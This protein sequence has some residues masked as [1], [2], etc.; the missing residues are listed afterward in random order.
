MLP[1][2]MLPH[3]DGGI[4]RPAA[5]EA[6]SSSS[7]SSS[8]SPGGGY[9]PP[10]PDPDP[11]DVANAAHLDDLES[12]DAVNDIASFQDI[13]LPPPVRGPT[14][15]SSAGINGGGGGGGGGGGDDDDDR[16]VASVANGPHYRRAKKFYYLLPVA[17]K[18]KYW[19]SGCTLAAFLVLLAIGLTAAGARRE[20][21]GLADALG[22][23][24]G[25]GDD[26]GGI[27]IND[28]PPYVPPVE[29]V[30]TAG[31]A[32]NTDTGES[33][34]GDVEVG[35]GTDVEDP[36]IVTQPPRPSSPPA[37]ASE[38]E[39]EGSQPR[40]YE[41]SQQEYQSFLSLDLQDHD[42]DRFC[43]SLDM[44]LC[45]YDEYCPNGEGGSPHA[46]GP[47]SLLLSSS[48]GDSHTWSTLEETQ[49]APYRDA[50]PVADD[51]GGGDQAGGWVQVGIVPEVDGG[52]EDVGYGRC[53][54]Y[55]DWN[56][57]VPS[58]SASTSTAAAAADGIE[59][60]VSEDHRSWILC[61]RD[62]R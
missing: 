28:A 33:G 6:S 19:I 48:T 49:W 11:E 15:S 60:V 59:D 9:E 61:C 56:N 14:S 21:Q 12:S 62:R 25:G 32:S 16:S 31:D 34:G 7:S 46:G 18:Y 54:T 55:A 17:Q 43:I 5:T 1:P 29:P 47:P 58:S 22:G 2:S 27:L 35:D 20:A 24:R 30:P 23:G 51:G 36:D 50:N 41:T 13:E 26:G 38:E 57:V 4:G 10:Y 37:T 39:E 44:A 8:T 42:A 52:G 3:H 40:W 45:R 53:Y